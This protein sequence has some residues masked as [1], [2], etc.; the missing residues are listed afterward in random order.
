MN[1]SSKTTNGSD[2]PLDPKVIAELDQLDA[3]LRG[4]AITDES[5][6]QLV[7]DVQAQAPEMPTALRTQ[8]GGDVAAGFPRFGK[9]GAARAERRSTMTKAPKRRRLLVGGGLATA[10]CS[11]ILV[12][13]FATSN[14][15]KS[16]S[17]GDDAA[18]FASTA[19]SAPSAGDS[20]TSSGSGA[21]DESAPQGLADSSTK[22]EA[23]TPQARESG[24]SAGAP[25]PAEIDQ[26]KAAVEDAGGTAARGT[27]SKAA[28]KP[29][30]STPASGRRR[31]EQ[32][33]EMVVRV[34]SGKLDEAAGKVGD[35]TRRAGGFVADSQVS[36]R[37][38][39]AGSATFT[40]Q[41]A[42]SK[43]DGA[44]GSLSDLVTVTS[45]DQQSTDITS[46]FDTA[47]Q[48]L[49]D[50][51]AVRK[52]LLRSLD[53]A[54][55]AGE[56]ASLRARIADNRKTIAGLESEILKLNQRTNLTTIA[57]SLNAPS[58]DA[59]S[60]DDDGKWTIGDAVDDAGSALGAIGGAL[61]VVGA[62]LLPFGLL[63]GIGWSLHLLRRKRARE[64]A[65]DD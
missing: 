59:P 42:S 50:A 38:R 34:K 43:L 16:L 4:E 13:G 8:L 61:I 3:A 22:R 37:T 40:L 14:S 49:G 54:D 36:M 25:A 31:V 30:T 57:L 64:S 44:I 32:A 33:V 2:A 47:N 6:A 58:G 21:T 17:L 15:D 9:A 26:L 53:K 51:K 11:L 65:L 24:A 23:V 18:P 60:A 28:G 39:G 19:G 10:A 5:L 45:Q 52:A 46:S 48:R 56:I 35:I 27:S 20:A 1:R 7:R 55:S 29:S 63:G 62:V 12:V 41:V